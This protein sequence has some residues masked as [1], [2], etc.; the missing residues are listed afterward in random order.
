M[1]EEKK[2]KFSSGMVAQSVYSAEDYDPVTGKLKT[3]KPIPIEPYP[4]ATE[5]QLRETRAT[6]AALTIGGTVAGTT[7]DPPGGNGGNGGDSSEDDDDD[8]DDGYNPPEMRAPPKPAVV[9]GVRAGEVKQRPEDLGRIPPRFISDKHYVAVVAYL[10]NRHPDEEAI[11]EHYY[12]QW[13]MKREGT[14]DPLEDPP[15]LLGDIVPK[16]ALSVTRTFTKAEIKNDGGKS[17]QKW[18]HA[19]HD[20]TDM[21]IV[22]LT[23]GSAQP[24]PISDRVRGIYKSDTL[25]GVMDK[26]YDNLEKSATRTFDAIANTQE[27]GREAWEKSRELTRKERRLKKRLEKAGK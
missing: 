3:L 8:N 2:E 18:L 11:L 26:F 15:V 23:C 4:V 22:P 24:F 19:L 12:R 20:A 9:S 1:A 16:I 14:Y 27:Q 21:N 5:M 25:Q 7:P 6:G 17:A 10:E 13:A